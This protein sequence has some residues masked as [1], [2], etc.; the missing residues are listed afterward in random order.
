MVG[1]QRIVFIVVHS[2]HAPASIP[3]VWQAGVF[4][5]HS[6]SPAQARHLCVLPSQMGRL[7]VLQSALPRHSTHRLLITRQRGAAIGHCASIVQK[8]PPGGFSF[9]P[10]VIA[11]G[12]LTGVA[13][14]FAAYMASFCVPAT[15]L[16]MFGLHTNVAACRST[17]PP[18][19]PPPGPCGFMF[20][21]LVSP[22]L[23]PRA[24]SAPQAA[25]PERRM[26]MLP[27]A[28][29]PPPPSTAPNVPFPP[30]ALIV[31]RRWHAGW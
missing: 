20:V 4:P 6:L 16:S 3:P 26:E 31:S 23:P 5:P 19:P 29:P 30:F 13:P 7:A 11:S 28:P 18:P 10:R 1:V 2:V 21:V 8:P 9:I 12:L 14:Q 22:P 25:L 24:W 27:P 17:R 15:P